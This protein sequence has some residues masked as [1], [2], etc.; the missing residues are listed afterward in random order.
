M[1]VVAAR[2]RRSP[3]GYRRRNGIRDGPRVI[4]L[5]GVGDV[6]AE[7]QESGIELLLEVDVRLRPPGV[8]GLVD[9]EAAR[10][11]ARVGRAV[12]VARTA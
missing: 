1:S 8:A 7:L 3:P 10:R 9:A 5:A 12:G 4:A 11:H 2:A 6:L